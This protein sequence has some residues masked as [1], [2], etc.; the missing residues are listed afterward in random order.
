MVSNRREHVSSSVCLQL[1]SSLSNVYSNSLT[2]LPKGIRSFMERDD[3]RRLAAVQAWASANEVFGASICPV[4]ESLDHRY[5]FNA[6]DVP[7]LFRTS[8]EKNGM[9]LL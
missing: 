5:S 7:H 1:L 2:G 9:M 8:K 4:N 3:R 6:L